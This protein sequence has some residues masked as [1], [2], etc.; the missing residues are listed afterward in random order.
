MRAS[1]V[2]SSVAPG[3]VQVAVRFPVPTV[4]TM[5]GVHPCDVAAS[6]VRRN[7]L[8]SSQ[9]A[10][11]RLP[12]YHIVSLPSAVRYRWCVPKHRFASLN[13]PVLGSYTADCRPDVVCGKTWADSSDEPALQYAGSS[14]G[15]IRAVI[16]TRPFSSR[17]V[18]CTI[19]WLDQ[20]R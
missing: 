13:A 20:M 9:P 16:Q 12:V 7:A 5:N 14:S 4:S 17:I 6:P 11:S 15:R 2:G 8:V 1:L 18:L 19:V 3:S 10:T